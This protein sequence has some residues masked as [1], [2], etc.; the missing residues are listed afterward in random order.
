MLD[1][2]DLR[3]FIQS[4]A[5]GRPLTGWFSSHREPRLA[6]RSELGAQLLVNNAGIGLTEQV[7]HSADAAGCRRDG[8]CLPRCLL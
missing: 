5:G 2:E 4:D 7:R 6:A 3:T 8:F 1:V